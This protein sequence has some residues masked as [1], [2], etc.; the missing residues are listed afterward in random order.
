MFCL[1]GIAL[2]LLVIRS[3][4]DRFTTMGGRVKL[5]IVGVSLLLACNIST[6]LLYLGFA[7]PD[8]LSGILWIGF[9]AGTSC[10]LMNWLEIFSYGNKKT[11][12]NFIIVGTA[13]GGL[14]CFGAFSLPSLPV[15]ILLILF[16]ICSFAI[17]LFFY[18]RVYLPDQISVKQSTARYS[19]PPISF[20]TVGVYGVVFGISQYMIF[21]G[22]TVLLSPM[23]IGAAVVMGGISLLVANLLL[24]RPA[25]YNATQRVLFPIMVVAL[26]LIPFAGD[27]SALLCW[28]LLMAALTCFD[29]ANMAALVQV[30]NTYKLAPVAFI[31]QGRLPI[32]IGMLLGWL[33]GFVFL[34]SGIFNFDVMTMIALG[35]VVVLV[36]VTTVIPYEKSGLKVLGPGKEADEHHDTMGSWQLR[37]KEVA[38]KYGLSPRQQDVLIYLAKGRNA[39]YIQNEL[40]ISSHTAKSHIYQVYR[41]LGVHSQQEL[42]DLVEETKGAH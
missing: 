13:I 37:C 35:L 20:I 14:F 32:Q 22:E 6:L 15:I 28:A 16:P 25:N 8:V 10:G 27:L 23:I 30:T 34:G 41:K 31:A 39:E 24:N 33:L 26:L 7:I 36:I 1:A 12:T 38:K 29:I 40:V 5:A 42:I 4:A 2:G 18:T 9:G 11:A 21:S 3:F 19:L 17:L